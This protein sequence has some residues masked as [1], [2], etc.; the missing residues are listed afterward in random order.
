MSLAVV[1]CIYNECNRVN[2]ILQYNELQ[3]A[4]HTLSDSIFKSLMVKYTGYA[5]V[6]R[7]WRNTVQKAD[8]DK[9]FALDCAEFHYTLDYSVLSRLT[10]FK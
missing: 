6:S 4:I 8:K 7:L 10:I 1:E 2:N 3:L 9:P 5:F